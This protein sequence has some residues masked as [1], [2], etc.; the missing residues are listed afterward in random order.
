MEW[1]TNL[2]SQPGIAHDILV[3]SLIIALGVTFGKLRI[4]GVS[5]GIT[6]VLFFALIFAN[7]GI[8]VNPETAHFLKEFGLV[9]FVYCIGLQ[10]GPSFFNS[11]KKEAL[12]VNLLALLVVLI[13]FVITVVIYLLGDNNIA[14]VSGLMSGAVTNTPGL[15]AAQAV[16]TDL[17]HHKNLTAA[18]ASLAYAVTYPFGVVG[19]VVVLL[20]LKKI[21]KIDIRKEQDNYNK[22]LESN[23]NK[24]V[25]TNLSVSNPLLFDKPVG[26][27]FTIIPDTFVISRMYHDN[28]VMPPADDIHLKSGDVLLVVATKQ[29]TEKLKMVIGNESHLNLK[30]IPGDLVKR[31]IVVTRKE[32]TYKK[33]ED[34]VELTRDDCNIIRVDRSGFQIIAD[35]DFVLHI[36]DVVTVVGTVEGTKAFTTFLG[37]SIK[38]LEKPELAPIFL[39]IVLGVILG[40]IPLAIPG[41]PVPVKIGLAG[42]PLIIA[43]ILSQFGNLMRMYNYTTY[44]ANLMVRE[45]GIV[46]FLASIGLSSGTGLVDIFRS[47]QGYTWMGLGIIITMVPL[48]VTGLI[49]RYAAKK[50]FFEIC[51]LLSGASTD[52]PALAFT[53][54]LAG[55]N[56]PS[57]TYATVYP[58]TMIA[59]ILAAEILIILFL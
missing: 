57:L 13:G 39:G 11:L 10:V 7:T 12:H 27:L 29:V 33:L 25:S 53:L 40:A 37:N 9:L 22:M 6:W 36:G 32:A 1:L 19:I 2:F 42:G 59:R 38:K 43:L 58:L 14:V 23:P 5:L 3:Y 24:P 35:P 17:S 48:L 26:S 52:P 20:F 30:E 55:N 56:V 45:L 28:T 4:F 49:A 16:I 31:N 21:W 54:Q 51:G 15:G 34:I 18:D 8:N 44:S 50:S 47:G 46:L 41:I